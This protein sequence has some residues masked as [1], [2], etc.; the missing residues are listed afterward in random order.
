[1]DGCT[2]G[3]GLQA[4]PDEDVVH[5]LIQARNM[6]KTKEKPALDIRRQAALFALNAKAK[7][8]GVFL[9][10]CAIPMCINSKAGAFIRG[11]HEKG[12]LADVITMSRVITDPTTNSK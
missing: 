7:G 6:I 11:W 10:M 1:M 3:A 8:I 5:Q 2:D 9:C 12:W 4:L